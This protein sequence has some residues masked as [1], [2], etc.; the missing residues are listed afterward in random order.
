MCK[1]G[2]LWR[3]PFVCICV[4]VREHTRG[5]WQVCLS[6]Q[7]VSPSVQ[8]YRPYIVFQHPRWNMNTYLRPRI[9]VY[10]WLSELTNFRF[11][12]VNCWSYLQTEISITLSTGNKLFLAILLYFS[13]SWETNL[14]MLSCDCI[15]SVKFI[16]GT[17]S[18]AK[19]VY[20]IGSPEVGRL[21]QYYTLF[22]F[23]NKSLLVPLEVVTNIL[24]S[25][26]ITC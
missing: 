20:Y 23:R 11:L 6:D 12:L 14:L 7:R 1:V 18:P 2:I 25:Q 22:R 15:E 26:I 5:S 24:V 21:P 19:S 16:H 10:C 3:R 13:P 4:T 8:N 17:P 9:S